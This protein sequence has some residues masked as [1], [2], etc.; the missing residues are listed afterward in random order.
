VPPLSRPLRHS[1]VRVSFSQAPP[2]LSAIDRAPP[3]APPLRHSPVRVSFTHIP[4]TFIDNGSCATTRPST[5]TRP[6][7]SLS[8]VLRHLCSLCAPYPLDRRFWVKRFYFVRMIHLVLLRACDQ[9]L[10]FVFEGVSVY[11]H[12]LHGARNMWATQR[13]GVAWVD[14]RGGGDTV[15]AS[16]RSVR[17]RLLCCQR[18][19]RSG[20]EFCRYTTT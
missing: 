7:T 20:G 5:A 10:G 15:F 8:V 17:C 18:V 2:L 19:T 12:A 13:E 11:L 16:L 14:R 4:A 6:S 1:P 9:Q 3:L